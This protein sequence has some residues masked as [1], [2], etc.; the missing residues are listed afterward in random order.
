M[1]SFFLLMMVNGTVVFAHGALRWYGLTLC[2]LLAGAWWP[3]GK[4]AG[5]SGDESKSA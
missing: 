5:D 2:L 4:R 3:R 1:R